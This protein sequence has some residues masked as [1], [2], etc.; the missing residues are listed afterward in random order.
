MEWWR[1]WKAMR[2]P[3]IPLIWASGIAEAVL[4]LLPALVHQALFDWAVPSGEGSALLTVLALL[5]G[6]ESLAALAAALGDLASGLRAERVDARIKTGLLSRLWR[7]P[8]LALDGLGWGALQKGLDD[9]ER[10][11]ERSH[12]LGALTARALP[13]LLTAVPLLF[14][15]SWPLALLRLAILPIHWKLGSF[16]AERDRELERALWMRQR[17]W[18]TQVQET[19]E[20][21]RTV[22]VNSAID[23]RHRDIEV[24]A[25]LVREAAGQRRV[26]NTAWGLGSNLVAHLGT[27]L[28]FFVGATLIAFQH[29]SFGRFVA[30]QVVAAQALTGIGTLMGVIKTLFQTENP[31]RRYQELLDRPLERQISAPL[32]ANARL[33]LIQALNLGFDYPSGR[34]ALRAINLCL[35]PGERIALVGPSGCGKTTLAH[36]FLALYSPTEGRLFWSGVPY[37]HFSP[38]ELRSH[39]AAVLQDNALW[40]GTLRENLT[41]GCRAYTTAQLEEALDRAGLLDWVRG[42]PEGLETVHGAE[43]IRV[44]GGQRQRLALARAFLRRP[45]LLVLDEA[46]SALDNLTE[47]FIQ[48]S[49][50]AVSRDTTVVTI[51]H[52]LRTI[53]EADCIYVMHEGRLL[54]AGCHEALMRFGG[55]YAQLYARDREEVPCLS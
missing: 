18:F 42:L 28:V 17:N 41:L 9:A 38:A 53:Q 55:F 30:F 39:M 15:I 16:F 46:T 32:I 34:Q 24:G 5:V 43:G 37:G 35:W 48:D 51:A 50:R 2:E 47:T 33:P 20:G 29:L 3:E 54:E 22:K 52:R 12:A 6:A 13:A 19:F 44:S 40:T 31:K 25:L 49:L 21:I 26:W 27:A 7:W 45:R 14:W 36:L 8:V 11:T 10:M 23:S 1:E 4:A